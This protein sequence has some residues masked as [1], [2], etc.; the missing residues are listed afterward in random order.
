MMGRIKIK[1]KYEAKGTKI[2][3]GGITESNK[4]PRLSLKSRWKRKKAKWQY[5]TASQDEK[6]KR[7]MIKCIKQNKA[8]QAGCS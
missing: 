3:L 5:N 1:P 4:T 6:K 2:R 7:N 8:L